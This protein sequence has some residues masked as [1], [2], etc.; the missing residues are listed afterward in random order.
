MD[1]CPKCNGSKNC[2]HNRGQKGPRG[3]HGPAGP[4]GDQPGR[5]LARVAR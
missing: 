1:R 5:A 4:K 3:Y 2:Q